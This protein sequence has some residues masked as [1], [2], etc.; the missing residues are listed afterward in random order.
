MSTLA[1]ALKWMKK[2]NR[3]TSWLSKAKRVALASTVY[4][5]WLTRNRM[6]FEDLLA[7]LDSIAK[8][9]KTHVYKVMFTLYPDVLIIFE[10][11]A[12]DR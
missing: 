3:G 6:I 2:E 5:I 12:M 1:I 4:Y 9:I 11:L 8:R 7:N 10:S